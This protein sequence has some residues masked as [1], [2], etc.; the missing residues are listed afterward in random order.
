MVGATSRGDDASTPFDVPV[1]LPLAFSLAVVEVL[2]D[3]GLGVILA[4][5]SP[6]GPLAGLL[7]GLIFSG[8]LVGYM[9][10][11]MGLV[12]V[13]HALGVMVTR[14]GFLPWPRKITFSAVGLV[15]VGCVL[16]LTISPFVPALASPQGTV[17][18]LVACQMSILALALLMTFA[19]LVARTGLFKRLIAVLPALVIVVAFPHQFYYFY[20]LSRPDWFPVEVTDGM[21]V[22]AHWL[23]L[24]LPFVVAFYLAYQHMKNGLPVFVHVL[25][26]ILGFFPL[27]W[28]ANMP[29]STIRDLFGAMIG[30]P[31][32]LPAPWVLY[33][34]AML[35]L[36]FIF[37]TLV[38]TPVASH[39][40]LISRRRAGMGLALVYM[41]TFTPLTAPQAAFLTAGLVLWMKSIVLD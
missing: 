15:V 9:S 4:S 1:S 38:G 22:T 5:A 19:V 23:G 40:F 27:L 8:L 10:T 39:S 11:L 24:I 3:R 7:S 14:T 35:P 32:V 6:R 16:A 36:L 41:G 18:L 29:S 37:S 30:M 2:L 17:S 34:L 25:L 26:A 33:P 20:P 28:L 13:A 12:L 31:L 21:L